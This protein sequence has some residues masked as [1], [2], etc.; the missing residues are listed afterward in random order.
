[1]ARLPNLPMRRRFAEGGTT[2]PDLPAE[3]GG[4][5]T[6]PMEPPVSGS[7]D[8]VGNFSTPAKQKIG[9]T[10]GE[11]VTPTNLTA[12]T[13]EFLATTG[14]DLGTTPVTTFNQAAETD[15]TVTT[16]TLEAAQEY[17]AY[18]KDDN[19]PQAVAAQ[20]ALHNQAIIGNVEKAVSDKSQADIIQGVVSQEATVKYQMSELL[21]TIGT[22]GEMPSWASPAV[23]AVNAQ[24][25][26]RGLGAS[27]MAATAIVNAIYAFSQP[28]AAADAKTHAAM[29]IQNLS[30]KQQSTLQN[31][32]TYAAMD[33]TNAAATV[34]AQIQNA[35]S[36]LGMDLANLDSAQKTSVIEYQAQYQKLLT[37]SAAENASRQFNAKSVDQRN[38][39]V[40]EIGTQVQ[41]ANSTVRQFNSDQA[42]ATERFVS[43]MDDSRDKFNANM[44]A[45]IDQSN[46]NWRRTINTEN[47]ALANESNRINAQNL[48]GLTTTAQNQLWQ[49]YRDE[50]QWALTVSENASDR[51]HAFAIASQ[52]NDFS[53]EQYRTE[54][55][56]NTMLELG[57]TVLA[58]LFK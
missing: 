20:G 23:R 31:A 32:M 2:T 3:T 38:E 43:Q 8:L 46:A 45:Q 54:F 22:D 34:Q 12:G 41:N 26:Q 44:V 21:S 37:D 4:A 18:M 48:L 47:T 15:L 39:F 50:A 14:T 27:S 1:M 58:W 33:K 52:Q 57:S 28:I 42:N 29:D 24:M 19:L 53:A 40:A 6:F 9:I 16:P 25:L 7:D 49:R 10:E 36:F 35:K 51:A 13:N 5:G 55:T 30:I 56:D 17:T 11:K